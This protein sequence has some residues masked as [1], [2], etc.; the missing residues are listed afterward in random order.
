MD[1]RAARIWDSDEYVFGRLRAQ[2]H[3]IG[4]KQVRLREERLFRQKVVAGTL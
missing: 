1:D 2:R 3:A 4:S